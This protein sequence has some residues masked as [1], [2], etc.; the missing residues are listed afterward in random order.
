MK[1][2]INNMVENLEDVEA[3]HEKSEKLKET[4]NDYKKMLMIQKY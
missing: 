2:N 1:K 4:T 3:L